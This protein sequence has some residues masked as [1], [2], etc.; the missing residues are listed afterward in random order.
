V[1][2]AMGLQVEGPP[3]AM[4]GRFAKVSF[5][6]QRTHGPVGCAVGLGPQGAADEL[7]D[8]LVGD[9]ARSAG[10][11]FIMQTLETGLEIALAPD[12]DGRQRQM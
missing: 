12:A 5:V 4:D 3:K 1:T 7:R 9:R 2:L 11:Q 6:G 10:P 8:V